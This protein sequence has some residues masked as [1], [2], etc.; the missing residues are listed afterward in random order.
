MTGFT[1]WH[2]DQRRGEIDERHKHDKASELEIH[3]GPPFELTAAV[4]PI[5]K[6]GE[7]QRLQGVSLRIV[8]VVPTSRPSGD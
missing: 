6:N 5:A 8:V 3:L 7:A 2:A 4:E 1:V